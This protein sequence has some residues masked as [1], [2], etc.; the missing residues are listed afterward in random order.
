MPLLILSLVLIY[1]ILNFFYLVHKP[2]ITKLIFVYFIFVW[3]ALTTY[4]GNHELDIYRYL[5]KLEYYKALDWNGFYDLHFIN[6]MTEVNNM[7]FITQL[8]TFLVAK[9]GGGERVLLLACYTLVYLLLVPI[10]FQLRKNLGDNYT[11]LLTCFILFFVFYNPTNINGLRFY[12]ALLC[13]LNFITGY[14]LNED[15]RFFVFLILPVFVHF[16]FV[17]LIPIYMAGVLIKYIKLE[18]SFMLLLGS[19]IMGSVI[20][21][22]IQEIITSSTIG[23]KLFGILGNYTNSG[24]VESRVEDASSYGMLFT[25][26]IKYTLITSSIIYGFI[27]RRARIESCKLYCYGFFTVMFCFALLFINIP[28]L[29]RFSILAATSTFLLLNSSKLDISDSFRVRSYCFMLIP[30]T[31]LC[32]FTI[33]SSLELLSIK[34]ISPSFLYFIITDSSIY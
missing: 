25:W 19:F 9:I 31:I 8:L 18:R 23:F 22:Y 14:I 30:V 11:H 27:L 29:S 6:Y 7:D 2:S 10:H 26:S 1:P 16:S 32:I 5:N 4:Y 28:T 34:F 33:K 15:K 13:A 3:L 12:I 20:L 21:P 24:Y 17:V